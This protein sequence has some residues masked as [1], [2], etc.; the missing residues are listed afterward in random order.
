MSK[1]LGQP[2]RRHG[3]TVITALKNPHS[4]GRERPPIL[5]CQILLHPHFGLFIA[6]EAGQLTIAPHM[7]TNKRE[8]SQLTL[9]RP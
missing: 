1:V 6:D 2:L 4:G 3:R 9:I 5:R 8:V 7:T